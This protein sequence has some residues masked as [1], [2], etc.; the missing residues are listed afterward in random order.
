MMEICKLLSVQHGIGADDT[1]TSV[2]VEKCSGYDTALT[3]FCV[4]CKKDDLPEIVVWVTE[5]MKDIAGY[6]KGMLEGGNPAFGFTLIRST[7]NVSSFT[8]EFVNNC[9]SVQAFL[10]KYGASPS[11]EFSEEAAQEE[12]YN[13][14]EWAQ[15]QA[16]SNPASVVM[17]ESLVSAAAEPPQD[18]FGDPQDDF[19]DLQDDFGDLDNSAGGTVTLMSDVGKQLEEEPAVEPPEEL[20]ENQIEEPIEKPTVEMSKKPPEEPAV[21]PLE[22]LIENPIEEP[23]VEMSKKPPEE[24]IDETPL[25]NEHAVLNP[26]TVYAIECAGVEITALQFCN[27]KVIVPFS[28]LSELA[29]QILSAASVIEKK[30][31]E[32]FE[33]LT[34]DSKYAAAQMVEH[35]APTVIKEFMLSYVRGAESDADLVRITKMLDEF[36]SFVASQKIPSFNKEA[37]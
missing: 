29:E 36:C 19:E 25:E 12:R 5:N 6:V 27:G 24:L 16:V 34:N 13:P 8:E 28:H 23:K 22:E 11:L 3:G 1:E 2:V 21:E 26:E 7:L 33:I 10:D 20:I 15:G 4:V 14:G 37:L 30:D 35:Y 32:G 18:S 17:P 9:G 31:A